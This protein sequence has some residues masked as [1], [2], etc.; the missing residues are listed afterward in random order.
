[1]KISKLVLFASLF[2]LGFSSNS[3]SQTISENLDRNHSIYDFKM[4]SLEGEDVDFSQYRGKTILIVNT[5]SKCGFTHQYEGL[6][7]LNKVYKDKGL[8]ILGFPSNQFLGQEPG[9]S[10]EILEF[11]KS[12]YGV[13]FQMFEKINV[14]GEDASP[15]YKFLKEESPF[16][17]FPDKKTGD[18]LR[19]ILE[20][21]SPE[22]LE[23]N[24]IKWNF[25][26]FLVSKDGKTIKRFE[27]SV[28]PKELEK[29][30]IEIL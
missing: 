14:N 27:T 29:T 2:L 26:K 8:I 16:Q 11:C 22:F 6:E 1:M 10:I 17:G 5:A 7:E 15:L 20:K 19:G 13:S 12:N 23:G 3:Y 9:E 30:I 4:K 24:E 21:Y 25:T 28:S 18:M